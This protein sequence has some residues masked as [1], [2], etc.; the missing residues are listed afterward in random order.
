MY[1]A[2]SCSASLQESGL[3]FFVAQKSTKKRWKLHRRRFSAWYYRV[4]RYWRLPL[5]SGVALFQVLCRFPDL[6]VTTALRLEFRLPWLLHFIHS[7]QETAKARSLPST[8]GNG[9]FALVFCPTVS[10][11]EKGR[12]WPLGSCP[13]PGGSCRAGA[14]GSAQ[15]SRPGTG[16][17]VTRK[18]QLTF[19]FR[20][21][22]GR[23][24][25][26]V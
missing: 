3:H 23:K 16:P 19:D 12:L 21:R 2:H 4:A 20:C 6:S 13:L 14:P 26:P 22:A 17:F 9:A 24:G 1:P 25:C 10:F 11:K 5:M 18:G 8:S 15:K 7:W